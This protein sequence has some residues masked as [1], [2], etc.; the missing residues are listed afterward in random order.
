VLP[1]CR[2]CPKSFGLDI[3]AA[4]PA[5]AIE[6]VSRPDRRLAL[7]LTIATVPYVDLMNSIRLEPSDAIGGRDGSVSRRLT[8]PRLPF[9]PS[10]VDDCRVGAGTADRIVFAVCRRPACR[11]R[12]RMSWSRRRRPKAY[13]RGTEPLIL[14]RATRANGRYRVRPSSALMSHLA[15]TAGIKCRLPLSDR[16][17]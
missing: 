10:A 3:A 7:P 17:W 15:A 1:S 12:S 8:N 9:A 5:A 2:R 6:A 14:G 13:R 16:S 4:V 11:C